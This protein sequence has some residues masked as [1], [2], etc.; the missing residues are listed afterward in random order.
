MGLPFRL[1]LGL[2]I[3]GLLGL[4]GLP[5][6]S[7]LVRVPPAALLSRMTEP[8]LLEALRLSLVTSAAATGLVVLLGLPVAYL[9]A[10]RVFPGKRLLEVLIE[11]PMVLPPTVAGLALLLAF[12]RNGLAGRSLAMV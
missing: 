9:L 3:A 8:A 2:A 1:L 4:L 11:L 6:A 12:G 5:L 7:I 10:S